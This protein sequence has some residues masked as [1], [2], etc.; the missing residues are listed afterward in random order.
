MSDPVTD[1]GVRR[2][3]E[4]EVA[5]L[6]LALELSQVKKVRFNEPEIRPV[7]MRFEEVLFP[8][9]EVIVNRY[10]MAVRHKTVDQMTPY[11]PGAAGDKN[12]HSGPLENSIVLLSPSVKLD[13]RFPPSSFLALLC[14][15]T[16]ASD[17]RRGAACKRSL[18][19]FRSA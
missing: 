12:L 16:S 8:V 13:L 4:N 1:V 18:T 2:E 11:E 14:R 7:K 3:M 15:D 6:Y 17:R 9:R 10:R 5:A 19:C